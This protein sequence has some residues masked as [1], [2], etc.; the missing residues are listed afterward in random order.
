[1]AGQWPGEY[2]LCVTDVTHS[3]FVYEPADNWET[4]ATLTLP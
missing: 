2:T 1:M 3:N 4:C